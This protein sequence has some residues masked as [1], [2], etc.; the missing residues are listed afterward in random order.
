MNKV[1]DNCKKNTATVHMKGITN[2]I[3]AELNLCQECSMGMAGMVNLGG[4][5]GIG[6]PISMENIENILGNMGNINMDAPISLE[7]IFKGIME[8][9]QSMGGQAPVVGQPAANSPLQVHKSSGPCTTC[10]LS[11]EEFK[12]SGKLGCEA[13]YQAFPKE[14]VALFKSVQSSSHHEGKFP[15][16]FG[17]QMRQQREVDKLRTCLKSAIENENYEEAAKIR[18]QIRSLEVQP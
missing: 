6:M 2:G 8:S 14:I 4:L 10:G 3:K 18:D 12:A 15:K 1:C 16:R 13:C 9:V 7:N 17:T 5:G 11:Y